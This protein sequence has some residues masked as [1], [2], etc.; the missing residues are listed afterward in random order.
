MALLLNHTW[1]CVYDIFLYKEIKYEIKYKLIL[2]SGPKIL[3]NVIILL[4]QRPT[5]IPQ[6]PHTRSTSLNLHVIQFHTVIFKHS[7]TIA[8]LR[9]P[10][11]QLYQLIKSHRHVMHTFLWHN[12]EGI[13]RHYP[14]KIKP[15]QKQ[16]FWKKILN[17]TCKNSYAEICCNFSLCSWDFF[18]PSAP[19]FSSMS[20]IST[21]SGAGAFKSF[22]TLGSGG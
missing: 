13:L 11:S 22:M 1:R 16:F 2:A 5:L 3:P 4:R 19:S 7:H 15:S 6:E 17:V 18:S 12:I 9:G 21:L 14:K 10:H 8:L 20:P